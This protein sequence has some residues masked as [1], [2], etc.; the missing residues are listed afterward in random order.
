MSENKELVVRKEW[1]YVGEQGINGENN[2]IT[3]Y[4]SWIG[5]YNKYYKDLYINYNKKI[6]DDH[7]VDIIL[8]QTNTNNSNIIKI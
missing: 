6:F 1:G 7:I 3:S 2:N 4:S 8:E 5:M